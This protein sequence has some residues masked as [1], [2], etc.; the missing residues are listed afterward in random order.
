MPELC[1]FAGIII[2]LLFRDIDKHNKPHVHVRYGEFQA[3]IAVDGEFLDGKLPRRQLKIVTGWLAL[4][5]E[6]VYRAWNLAV[7][8]QQFDK[9]PPL[10]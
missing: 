9:I 2:Y 10:S 8:G 7:A 3:V 5:E 1:R 4:H 6:E